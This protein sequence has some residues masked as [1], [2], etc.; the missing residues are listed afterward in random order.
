MSE[1]EE[2]AVDDVVRDIP[3]FR[4]TGDLSDEAPTREGGLRHALRAPATRWVAG[5]VVVLVSIV[6]FR[7]WSQ[8]Q[9]LLSSVQADNISYKVP[10]APRL[11]PGAGETLYRIDP[12]QSKVTY[13]VDEN[14]VGQTASRATGS[15]SGI[16]GDV[17][18]NRTAPPSSHLGQIVVDVSQLRSDNNLRDARIRQDFLASTEHPLV[19]FT[20][21]SLVGMPA[22]IADGQSYDFTIVG[23]LTV[24]GKPT[25]VTWT[26]HGSVHD[27]Q[28]II[29]ATTTVKMSMLGIGPISLAGLVTTA[30]DVSLELHVVAVNPAKV[31][32]AD[33]VSAPGSTVASGPSPSFQHDV[34]PILARSCA[35]CHATGA[36]GADH[37]ELNTAGD[38]EK[39][40]DGIGT[41]TKA[42]YMPPWPASAV[43]VPLAHSKALS[44]ADI[45]TIVAWSV[46]GGKLDEPASTPIQ[47]TP[48]E[49][50]IQPRHD[51]TMQMPEAYTGS[52]DVPNDYRCFMLDPKFTAP[53]FVTGYEVLPGTR[54]EIHHVQ[55][56]HVN[57]AQAA[58]GQARRGQDGR[59]GWSCYSGPSLPDTSP[60]AAGRPRDF[61]GSRGLMAGWVPG[62]DPSIFPEHSGILFQPGDQVV[63]QVHYHYESAATP[64]RSSV[65]FQTE[66]GTADIKPIDIVNP[67]GPVEIPCLPG[68]TAALCDRAAALADNARLYGPLG[69]IAEPGLLAICRQ[70][71]ADMTRGFTGVATSTCDSRVPKSGLIVADMGHMHTLGKTFRLTLQPGAPDEKVLLDIPTWNFGWQ[72]NYQLQ[73]PLHVNKGDTIR[74]TCT[75][76]RAL[77]PTRA[78]KYIVFA[79]G[80]EDE[81]CFSTYALIPDA[82]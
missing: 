61:S 26:A 41:V 46:A 23:Q 54:A 11:A 68:D 38:A 47:A 82:G 22:S 55:V 77:D 81:M 40:A 32:V 1:I 50:G 76:D 31:P 25:P 16:A 51:V 73:T 48:G 28:V 62:Q 60:A 63:F 49:P 15:T 8:V 78:P 24:Q 7:V 66:A 72:M 53:T 44:Q 37:W 57:A 18:L 42:R 12:T 75:W 67:L 10:T 43:G 17:A 27:D 30:D 13:G 2:P 79:E 19:Q 21:Y 74:M 69:S 58:T 14:I 65:S 71:P 52:V 39:V 45:D 59:P 20:T 5:T 29:D 64:D 36:V 6:G 3:D 9:P 70:N 34:A 80:T 33:Q 35:S 56:F 4:S